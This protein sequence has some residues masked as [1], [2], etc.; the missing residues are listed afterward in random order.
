MREVINWSSRVW[1]LFIFL[2]ASIVIAV[3]VALSDL[4]L[5]ILAFV[6]MALTL[7]FSFTSRLRL[8]AS[9]KTLIVGKAEIESR[10]I[11][12]VIPLNEEEMKYERGAGLDPRAYLAIR[13]WVKAGMKVMLDDPRDPTPYWL[14]SSRRASEFKTYLSK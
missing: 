11:K 4:A 14:V 12:A 6:L 10:Y 5:A 3:G 9:N 1:L 2:N 13:F 7:F 8:I